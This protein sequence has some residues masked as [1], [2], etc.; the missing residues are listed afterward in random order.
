MFEISLLSPQAELPRL[1]IWLEA[2]N[3]RSRSLANKSIQ[4][5][6]AHNYARYQIPNKIIDIFAY[7]II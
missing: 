6:L 2:N 4:L 3:F 5:G 1:A 7:S